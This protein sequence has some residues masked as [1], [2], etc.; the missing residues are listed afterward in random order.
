MEKEKKATKIDSKENNKMIENK[1]E[2]ESNEKNK[3]EAEK[4]E[5]IHGIDLSLHDSIKELPQQQ[6]ENVQT[7]LNQNPEKKTEP[8]NNKEITSDKK[9]KM[10]PL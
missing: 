10:F 2:N 8:E 9:K 6:K 5:K 7:N 3:C 4:V 1:E